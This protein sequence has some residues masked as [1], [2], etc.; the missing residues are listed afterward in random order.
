MSYTAPSYTVMPVNAD[1]QFIYT[2]APSTPPC[3]TLVPNASGVPDLNV[4][5]NSNSD[6]GVFVVT[7]VITELWSNV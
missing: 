3:V 5:S 6:L 4:V 1:K 2:L 7:I